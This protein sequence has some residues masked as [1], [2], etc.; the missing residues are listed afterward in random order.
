MF[1]CHSHPRSLSD[2]WVISTFKRLPSLYVLLVPSDRVV[3]HWE[4][5]FDT[6]PHITVINYHAARFCILPE[7]APCKNRTKPIWPIRYTMDR[8]VSLQL[9]GYSTGIQIRF[10]VELTH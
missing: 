6:S 9:A 3:E 8:W 2:C 4:Q 7:S 1:I 10:T 5:V